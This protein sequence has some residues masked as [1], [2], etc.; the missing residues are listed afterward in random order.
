MKPKKPE[1][2]CECFFP[3]NFIA[4]GNEPIWC[5]NC[6]ARIDK[7]KRGSKEYN[8]GL[9]DMEAYYEATKLSIDELNIIVANAMV[10]YFKL[11]P[12]EIVEGV[13]L[14]ELRK[15]IVKAII[16]AQKEQRK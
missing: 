9:S 7:N 8:Q 15:K 13:I 6:K 5:S 2:L 3:T 1:K 10:E 4:N 16:D 12:M 14:Y 11:I